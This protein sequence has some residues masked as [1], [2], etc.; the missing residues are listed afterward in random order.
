MRRH[1]SLALVLVVALSV[2]PHK[3]RAMSLYA[4]LLG[5]YGFTPQKHDVQPYGFGLGASAGLTLPV[6]PIYLGARLLWFAGGTGHTVVSMSNPAGGAAGVSAELS[7]SYLT[8]GIDLGYEA[9]LGPF[10]LRPGLGIGSA[11]LNANI[12]DTGGLKTKFNDSTLYLSPAL[13]LL[14]KPGL[15]FIGAEARYIGL[16]EKNHL[17]GIALLAQLGLTL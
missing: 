16:T 8:Y 2:A 10:A 4:G 3:A 9:A 7:Q 12:V 13:A 11:R 5:G 1:A 15:I 14:F 6:V 17:S